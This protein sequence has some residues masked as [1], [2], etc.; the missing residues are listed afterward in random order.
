MSGLKFLKVSAL[1]MLGIAALARPTAAFAADFSNHGAV[2]SW[3]GKAIQV[4]SDGVAPSACAK[5]RPAVVLFMTPTLT[6][7]G[8]FVADDSFLFTGPPF[9][10]HTT[11]HGQWVPTSKTDFIADYIFMVGPFPPLPN[12]VAGFR[13]RWE[14]HVVDK[15]T[16]V[17]W[18][19][20]YGTPPVPLSWQHLEENEFP[21][22]PPEATSIVT[23]KTPFIRDP[24]T[25]NEDDC[26][27]V[28]KFTLKRVHP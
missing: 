2:G 22:F 25:C 9:A 8:L 21:T 3:F 19:N 20:G 17:G 7:D 28:F 16:L 4:C 27:L 5:G 6:R 23:P 14:A 15:E 12:N 13:A 11:A 10:P 18:V 24:H 1:A 26:P